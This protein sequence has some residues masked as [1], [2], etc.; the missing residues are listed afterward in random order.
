MVFCF[1]VKIALN[2]WQLSVGLNRIRIDRMTST[3]KTYFSILYI[4][5]SS[6][7][8]FGQSTNRDKIVAVY[9]QDWYD[10]EL[11]EN[12]QMIDLLN[13]YLTHGF[14]VKTVSEGKYSEFVQ[15]SYVP[16]LSKN[17]DSVSVQ[18]FLSDSQTIDFNPLKY[19]FFPTHENQ[20]FKLAGVNKIIYIKPIDFL[21]NKPND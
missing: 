16:V 17:N 11:S 7:V 21:I 1:L 4:I 12:K 14:L 9:G 15:M 6:F 2:L 13:E 3:M 8:L 10:R 19:R 18:E 5:F 20:V